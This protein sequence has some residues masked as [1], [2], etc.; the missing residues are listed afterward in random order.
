MN[1]Y[2]LFSKRIQLTLIGLLL[3]CGC[4]TISELKIAQ[5]PSATVKSV[6]VEKASFEGATL[7]FDLE[8][9]NPNPVSLNL[10]GLAYGLKI[11]EH[12]FLNG[13]LENA[14]RLK[15]SSKSKLTAPL[16][17]QF[18]DLL[19]AVQSLRGQ[20]KFD[21]QFEG[22][23]DLN[24]PGLGTSTIPV[25]YAGEFPILRPP[26]ISSINVEQKSLNFTGAELMLSIGIE[27]PNQFDFGMRHFDYN[28]Q[29]NEVTWAKGKVRDSMKLKANGSGSIEIPISLNFL[30]LGSSLYRL[31]TGDQQAEYRLEGT[32]DLESNLP[33]MDHLDLPFNRSG[34]FSI[35]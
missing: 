2:K 6:R 1:M 27:N 31:L 9:E 20:E 28:F 12:P 23:F 15:A 17:I 22:G 18:A 21:Y 24:L 19:S 14:G 16:V 29:V 4:E 35:Q 26:S 11:N 30:K 7:L 32:L 3:A 13:K 33:Y 25:K 34:E 8:L 5:T 10:Q